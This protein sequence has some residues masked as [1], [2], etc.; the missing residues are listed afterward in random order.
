MWENLSIVAL[1]VHICVQYVNNLKGYFL[2]MNNHAMCIIII[3]L[4]HSNCCDIL[5]A[6]SHNHTI[7]QNTTY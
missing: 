4:F 7:R 3:T 6:I 1:K 2:H 5:Q